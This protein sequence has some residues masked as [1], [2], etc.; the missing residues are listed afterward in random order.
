MSLSNA[1][2]SSLKDKLEQ[3]ALL[4]KEVEKVKEEIEKEEGLSKVKIKRTSLKKA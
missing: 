2:L 3:K 4:E 1:K